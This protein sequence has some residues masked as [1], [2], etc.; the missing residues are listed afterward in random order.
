[1]ARVVAR[2]D[3]PRGQQRPD[4]PWSKTIF[5]ETH[6]KGFTQLHPAVP[7]ALRGTFEGLGEKEIVDYVKSLGVSTIELL[8][9]HW[10]PDYAHL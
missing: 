4:V 5:Y 9:V 8:P 7:E 1:K 3:P 6:V 2:S 10:F